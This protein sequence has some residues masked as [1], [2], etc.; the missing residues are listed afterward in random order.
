MAYLAVCML[1]FVGLMFVEIPG[2]YA[3]FNVVPSAAPALWK[4]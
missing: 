4:F 2:L 1:A 3:L